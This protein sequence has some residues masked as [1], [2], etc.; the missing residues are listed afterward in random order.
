MCRDCHRLF[1]KGLIMAPG[2]ESGERMGWRCRLLTD[3]ER[4][5]AFVDDSSYPERENIATVSDIGGVVLD[6]RLHDG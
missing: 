3:H 2:P 5:W 4:L 1:D 6:P